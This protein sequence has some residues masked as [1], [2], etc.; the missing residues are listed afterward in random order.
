M[1]DS[2]S[3]LPSLRRGKLRLNELHDRVPLAGL[4]VVTLPLPDAGSARVGQHGRPDRLEIGEEPVPL[5]GGP[6]L[7]RP[8]GDEERRTDGQ[9]GGLG[10]A[11]DVRGAADVLVRR[12]RA[13]P[14][15]GVG[16]VERVVLG[17]RDPHQLVQGPVEVRG[18]RA[19]DVGLEVVEIDLD[20][21]V[22]DP[23]W[24]GL[25]LRV[26]AEVLR[27]LVGEPRDLLPAG[28]LQ[29]Q[30]AVQVVGEHRARRADLRAH[31]A[32][33]R[34]PRRG[35]R[36]D[37]R[38]EVLDDRAGATLD[39]EHA[40]HRE[41]DVLRRRPAGQPPREADTDQAR[42][43]G[44]ERPARH[45]VHRVGPA[46]TDRGHAQPARVRGVA[47]G[48]DHHPARER[49]LLQHHLVDDPRAGLPEPDPV[50]RRDAAQELVDLRVRVEGTAQVRAR[51]DVRLDQM[52]AVHR[53]G[54]RDPRQ[55]R[56]HELQQ[57]HLGGGVLHR[58]AVGS[59]VG[60]VDAPLRADPLR[61]GGVR[62]ED[63]VR[64]GQRSVQPAPRD[65]DPLR[66]AAVEG[67]DELDRRGRPDLGLGHGRS[68]VKRGSD[69]RLRRA[70]PLP[71]PG[72]AAGAT[73]SRAFRM[74]GDRGRTLF[75]TRLSAKTLAR[76]GKLAGAGQGSP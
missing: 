12:V 31:V 66:V 11:S 73:R 46:D 35:D 22:V 29:V 54:D 4:D 60:V 32:D 69:R 63:L 36:L 28:C 76:T 6:H 43:P 7:L 41:D 56:G 65:L 27:V 13:G 74:I 30:R 14:D 62:K 52:V 72:H 19:H 24:V 20:H 3:A 42:D 5:D 8:G 10:L 2:V 16:D 59:V 1:N 67:L 49:V 39:R 33:G 50:L 17:L 40:R 75:I 53:G 61:V 9:P 23:F 47:V 70:S 71:I 34:L 21:P 48:P 51:A 55:P 57:R 44:V 25:D 18:V 58:D 64:K 38:P 26:A 15:Q 68:E 45:H 37:T